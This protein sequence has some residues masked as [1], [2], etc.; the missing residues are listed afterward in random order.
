MSAK[1]LNCFCKGAKVLVIDIKGGCHARS[2]LLA[3]GLTPGCPVEVLS[4]GQGPIRLKVRGSEI[5][6]GQ[7]M[8]DKLMVCDSCEQ[9]TCPHKNFTHCRATS[10]AS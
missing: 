5:A 9:P 1:P 4:D 10:K 6:L 8:C 7:G 2:R 3:M